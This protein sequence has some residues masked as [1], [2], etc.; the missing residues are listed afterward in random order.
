MHMDEF[1]AKCVKM[2]DIFAKLNDTMQVRKILTADEYDLFL[3]MYQVFSAF[4]NSQ[5]PKE[6]G[7][8]QNV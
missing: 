3:E 8:K 5:K 7:E 4:L 6:K 2:A 1:I